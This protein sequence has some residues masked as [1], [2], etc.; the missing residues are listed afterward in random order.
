MYV[1]AIVNFGFITPKGPYIFAASFIWSG[2]LA[3]ASVPSIINNRMVAGVKSV[4]DY[5]S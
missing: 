5:N 4:A 3:I 1:I 2:G